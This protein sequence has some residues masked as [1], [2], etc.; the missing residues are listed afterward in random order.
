MHRHPSTL[1]PCDRVSAGLASSEES[2]PDLQAAPLTSSPS[3]SLLSVHVRDVVSS[4]KDIFI[5]AY[6]PFMSLSYFHYFFQDPVSQYSH[7]L[8]VLGTGTSMYNLGRK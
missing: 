4:Y 7:N 2:L 5:L 8:A 3:H 1:L 6:G